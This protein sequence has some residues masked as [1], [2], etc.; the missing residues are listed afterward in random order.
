MSKRAPCASVHA[1]LLARIRSK[2]RKKEEKIRRKRRKNIRRIVQLSFIVGGLFFAYSMIIYFAVIYPAYVSSPIP[3]YAEDPSA[4][5][6]FTS[7]DIIE[8]A[9]SSLLFWFDHVEPQEETAYVQV[10]VDFYR[11]MSEVRDENSTF[12]V[13]QTFQNISNVDVT[14]NGQTPSDYGGL[15]TVLYYPTRVTN[16]LLI[17]IP[18]ENF[19]TGGHITLS[20]SFSWHGFFWRQSFHEYKM[21]VS[22]NTGFPSFVHDVGLPKQ[23]IN[24]NGML[25]PDIAERASFSIADPEVATISD[26]RPN[27]DIVG[28]SEGKAWHSWDIKKR[29]DRD[30][31]A[32]TA[33]SIELEVDGLKTIYESS[34]AAVPLGLGI[35]LPLLVSSSIEYAKIRYPEHIRENQ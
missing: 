28:F 6:F 23:A 3:G 17:D 27:P 11:P 22:F 12:F 31:Y 10:Y 18:N 19:T 16:Y 20:L 21:L 33:V 30:R 26:A 32:S 9:S 4:F 8:D 14:V 35:G 34:W 29:S 13:L 25:I 2:R 1:R 7:E 5:L 15:E 24:G